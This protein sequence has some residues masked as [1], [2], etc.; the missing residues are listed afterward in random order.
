MSEIKRR[1]KRRFDRFVNKLVKNKLDANDLSENKPVG[2]A[3]DVI[4]S[5]AERFFVE[6]PKAIFPHQFVRPVDETVFRFLKLDIG[7]FHLDIGMRVLQSLL[8]GQK[9]RQDLFVPIDVYLVDLIDCFEGVSD[10]EFLP[11]KCEHGI[12]IVRAMISARMY[13]YL[14]VQAL[15]FVLAYNKTFLFDRDTLTIGNLEDEKKFLMGCREHLFESINVGEILSSWTT[16]FSKGVLNEFIAG[17]QSLDSIEARKD[18]ITRDAITIYE[19]ARTFDS[20]SKDNIENPIEKNN[21]S[22]NVK[23]DIMG[24]GEENAEAGYAMETIRGVLKGFF[25]YMEIFEAL[26]YGRNVGLLSPREW[27]TVLDTFTDFYKH[28]Q[29]G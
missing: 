28:C 9:M 29:E 6:N 27:E 5:L 20:V 16:E 11:M 13:I 22:G 4:A 21:L 17:A 23:W 15:Q 2:E 18:L 8:Q 3:L 7:G 10:D 25:G 12:G 14:A 1:D 26:S 19:L 24:V